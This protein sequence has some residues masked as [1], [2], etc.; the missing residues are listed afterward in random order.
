MLK[1]HAHAWLANY[2]NPIAKYLFVILHQACR[3][4]ILDDDLHVNE[5]ETC[6]AIG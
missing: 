4:I 3:E 2:S 6:P 1:L 5:P